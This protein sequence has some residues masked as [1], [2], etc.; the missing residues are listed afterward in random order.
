MQER[1]IW[2][3]VRLVG[4]LITNDT[5]CGDNDGSLDFGLKNCSFDAPIG[6]GLLDLATAYLTKW[7]WLE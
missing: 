3:A 4:M 7:E 6:E 2:T 5:I 1:L